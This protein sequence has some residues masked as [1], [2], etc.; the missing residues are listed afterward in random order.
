MTKIAGPRPTILVKGAGAT[1]RHVVVTML[2]NWHEQ[3]VNHFAMG[4]EAT[5]PERLA[6]SSSVALQ[7]GATSMRFSSSPEGDKGLESR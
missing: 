6:C 2:H 1:E 7:A 3:L 4:G 5:T